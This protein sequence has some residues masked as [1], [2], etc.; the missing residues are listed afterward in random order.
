MMKAITY[1]EKQLDTSRKTIGTK[2]YHFNSIP[3]TNTWLMNQSDLYALE[4]LVV[5][6]DEQ[7]AGRGRLER[8]WEG[9]TPGQLYCSF[10]LKP[11][12]PVELV[13]TIT[14]WIGLA[15]CRVLKRLKLP[16]V[17]IKWPNDVLVQGKKVCG[18]LCEMK[19][20]SMKKYAIV[21]GIGVNLNGTA[22]QY[23]Q[24][25]HSKAAT[26]EELSGIN[27]NRDHFMDDLLDEVDQIFTDL[28][29][30]KISGLVSEWNELSSSL[31]KRVEYE[32]K[33][34]KM[35]GMIDALDEKGNLIIQSDSGEKIHLLSG[36]ILFI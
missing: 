27:F 5:Y 12:L 32:Y 35:Q 22:K 19:A 24:E 36:E 4:G 10:V 16:D 29:S 25:L 15:L 17:S 18:I 9:G 26:L 23:S 6:A 30:S 1:K 28:T 2:A 20:E 11:D 7:T 13:S 8:V 33:N 34:H 3:S 31:G 21:A 14:L